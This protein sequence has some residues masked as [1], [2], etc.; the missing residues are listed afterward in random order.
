MA[1]QAQILR[2][3]LLAKISALLASK[4][5]CQNDVF[6]KYARLARLAD[7]CQDIL[8]GLARLADIRQMPFLKKCDSPCQIRTINERVSQIWRV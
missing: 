8:R 5:I 3:Q 2:V 7:I 1:T 6:W 4:R